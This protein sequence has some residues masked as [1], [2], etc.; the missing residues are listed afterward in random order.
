MM[1]PSRLHPDNTRIH[2]FPHRYQEQESPNLDLELQ[3]QGTVLVPLTNK[4]IKFKR[5]VGYGRQGG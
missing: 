1:E 5:V 4:S 2:S 3:P